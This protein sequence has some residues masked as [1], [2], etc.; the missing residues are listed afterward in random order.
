M[1]LKNLSE[2]G[3]ADLI[4]QRSGAFTQTPGGREAL[5]TWLKTGRKE[6]LSEHLAKAG[7]TQWYLEQTALEIEKETSEIL[8]MLEASDLS[9]MISIG[10]GNG[11][12]EAALISNRSIEALLLID[13]EETESH[14]HG[15][16]Q[17]GSGYASLTRTREFIAA[18]C[19][20]PIDI[21]TCNPMKMRLPEFN[22]TF[23][24]ST[25]SMGFHYPCTSYANFIS[26]NSSDNAIVILDL[27]RGCTDEGF[28]ALLSSFSIHG[29]SEHK[30]YRRVFLRAREKE[31][32]S[33]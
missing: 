25:L 30:K 28:K 29:I 17:D 31:G 24:I 18:T 16:N 26:M 8:G 1:N 20:Y 15:Y 21:V 11:M 2:D 10:P 3:I 7:L 9:R 13:I 5:A 6:G 33:L 4:L 23:L 22:F 27:R 19:Q 32:N 14:R 12:L